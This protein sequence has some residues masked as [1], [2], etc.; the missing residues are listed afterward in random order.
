MRDADP[1][2]DPSRPWLTRPFR[3][4]FVLLYV[5]AFAI[6]LGIQF[7]VVLVL[8]APSGDKVRWWVALGGMYLG[9]IGLCAV[10]AALLRY[11]ATLSR[12]IERL[13]EQSPNK[14]ANAP[15]GEAPRA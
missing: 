11:V 10:I 2:S 7:G 15:Q 1:R 9:V 12:E 13:K 3:G 4:Y 6:L 8:P 5:S 14:P